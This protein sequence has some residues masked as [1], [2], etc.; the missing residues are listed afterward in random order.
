MSKDLISR[1]SF[2]NKLKKASNVLLE[3]HR[4]AI[5]TGDIEMAREASAQMAAI[6]TV[7]KILDAEPIAYNLDKVLERLRKEEI[8]WISA[9]DY[10]NSLPYG[11]AIR[12]VKAAAEKKN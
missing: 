8:K 7:M 9:H 5:E 2:W 11:H 6:D 1:S 10:P 4:N 12:I 3:A